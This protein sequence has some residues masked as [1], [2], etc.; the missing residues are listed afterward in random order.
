MRKRAKPV[1]T[2]KAFCVGRD[3]GAQ[4]PS[5]EQ[6]QLQGQRFTQLFG[7]SE[8][9]LRRRGIDPDVYARENVGKALKDRA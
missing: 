4:P 6:R 1:L 7:I 8:D 5:D 2:S 9:E 3:V